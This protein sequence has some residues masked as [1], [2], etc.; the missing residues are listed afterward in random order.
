M[1]YWP[2][3]LEVAGSTPAVACWISAIDKGGNVE[4]L[5]VTGWSIVGSSR[6]VGEAPH[7][8]GRSSTGRAPGLQP[9]GYRFDPVRFQYEAMTMKLA[10]IHAALREAMRRA[11]LRSIEVGCEPIKSSKA[12]TAIE[13][14]RQDRRLTWK[15]L[16]L[17]MTI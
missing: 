12:E 8:R 16:N 7:F 5:A 3:K 13:K 6:G 4:P 9:G 1:S 11:E 2:S 17:P 10:D 15:E 14:L